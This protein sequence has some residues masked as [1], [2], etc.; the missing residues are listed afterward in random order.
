MSG[1]RSQAR[2][3]LLAAVCALVPIA[4]VAAGGVF[5][6]PMYPDGSNAEQPYAE[7]NIVP[8]GS[9]TNAMLA[10]MAGN[11]TK[12]NA[13]GASASPTDLAMPG[14]SSSSAALNWTTNTGFGCNTAITA[15]TNANLTGPITSVGNATSIASQTGT[16][17]KFVVD[18]S[19]TLITPT[20][21]GN[22]ITATLAASGGLTVAGDGLLL[23]G[24]AT[25]TD[26]WISPTGS[27]TD[28]AGNLELGAFSATGTVSPAVTF[29]TARHSPSTPRTLAL[30]NALG[31][32][33]W[34]GYDGTSYINGA[35]IAA[36]VDGSV[37]TGKVPGRIVFSTMNAAGT[38][39]ERARI[40]NSGGLTV[41]AF[42][43]DPG[44]GGIS[45]TGPF[46]STLATGT[47]PFSVSS[48]T[49]VANLNVATAGNADTVTT[50]A[51]LTGP[52]TSV[53]NA[54]SIASQTGTGTKF[55]VDTSPTI[56]GPTL[57]GA[58]TLPGSGTIDS[59]GELLIGLGSKIT[60]PAST[61][62]QN[63]QA[64]HSGS[65]GNI[66][67][68]NFFNGFNGYHVVLGHSRGSPST[69]GALTSGDLVGD[70]QF[71]ADDGSTNGAMTVNAAE[72]HVDVDGPVSTGVVPTRH[73]W[74]TMN[75]GGT[76]AERMRLGSDGSLLLGLTSNAG[77]GN[78]A[79]AGT[80]AANTAGSKL[81][82]P[83]NLGN[84]ASTAELDATS[85][86]T[87]ATIA[88]LTSPTL[89]AGKTYLL[90]GHLSTS[91]GASGGIKV[92]FTAAGG[93][94]LTSASITCLGRNGA[95]VGLNT[96]TTAIGA[97]C[98]AQTAAVTDIWID[99]AIVVNASGTFSLQA[100]QNASNATTTKVLVNS[101]L[102]VQRGNS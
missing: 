29:S 36:A 43:S 31:S 66:A 80:I 98:Y 33:V 95:T 24:A 61:T 16:G 96:T 52:I 12:G 27:T 42:G 4:A 6:A 48:T 17:T 86:T 93:L 26:L 7:Q 99:G 25:N 75:T 77:A 89:T 72:Y 28:V 71:V 47:A 59:S 102:S 1:L 87:L 19:P 39:A 85:N 14:C 65:V 68:L 94:T 84:L 34:N 67:F 46:I 63:L 56:S 73:V 53:G 82:D 40:S 78:F 60:L 62:S 92:Q 76:Y 69:A 83:I 38:F 100:A 30:G 32:V 64:V 45:I 51:N 55:V 3:M 88:G 22:N 50:N 37:A 49:R 54:T 8:N 90:H 81:T 5:P 57:T 91:S 35:T 79:A 58:T 44:V 18:T 9:I 101:F 10:P 2:M 97:P 11:T 20:I 23:N 21:T 74:N 41:G 15:T 70:F 13:T